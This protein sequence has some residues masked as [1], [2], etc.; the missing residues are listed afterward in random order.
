MLFCSSVKYLHYVCYMSNVDIY[1]VLDYP[2]YNLASFSHLG[3][4]PI[5][6]FHNSASFLTYC[7]STVVS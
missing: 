7:T 2:F 3:H 5:Y 1:N 4:I 6:L